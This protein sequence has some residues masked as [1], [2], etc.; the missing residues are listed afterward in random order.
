MTIAP[1]FFTASIYITLSKTIIFFAPELSRFK[2]QL[3]YW[4]F[5][6]FDIVCLILQAA[7]GALSIMSDTE[8]GSQLG[9]DISM[10]GLILQVIII[11]IFLFAF[12]DYMIR[13]LRSGRA[14]HF[15]WRLNAFF[16]GLAASIGFILMRCIYRVIE[17][18]GGYDG[19]MITHEIPFIILEG[20][21]VV[22]AVVALC[23]GNP[24]LVFSKHERIV[25]SSDSNSE[26]GVIRTSS[27]ILS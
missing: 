21:V 14:S 8:S 6:P 10:A 15:G 13:Y 4:I 27:P 22:L 11:V 19:E 25:I 12:G 24:G 5:I 7:G 2:P 1:V 17:L 16:G 26:K 20:V 23:F 9:I 3:F 18:R